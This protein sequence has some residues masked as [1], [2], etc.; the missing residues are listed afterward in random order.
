[1]TWFKKVVEKYPRLQFSA[2][3]YDESLE[4]KGFLKA[5]KGEIIVNNLVETPESN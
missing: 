1:M 4:W 5:N 3:Y 2:E